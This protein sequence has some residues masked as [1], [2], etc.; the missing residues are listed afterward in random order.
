MT[1]FIK[2]LDPPSLRYGQS[3]HAALERLLEH[4]ALPLLCAPTRPSAETTEIESSLGEV[5]LE[6]SLRAVQTLLREGPRGAMVRDKPIRSWMQQQ[7][8]REQA[9]ETV[10]GSLR[11]VQA[12]SSTA[13]ARNDDNNDMLPKDS[14]LGE[15]G[16]SQD[17]LASDVWEL[18][19][20]GRLAVQLQQLELESLQATSDLSRLATDI[21]ALGCDDDECGAKVKCLAEELL[22]CWNLEEDP[23]SISP[24]QRQNSNQT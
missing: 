17:L 18:A 24:D 16:Q 15:Q 13:K 8:P 14:P 2:H 3:V 7:K 4:M 21:S 10:E 19:E 23:D 5:S 9:L 20:C 22:T 6:G 12:A 1:P 11:A